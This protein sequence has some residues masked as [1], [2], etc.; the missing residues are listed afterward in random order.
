MKI[1]LLLFLPLIAWASW[2]AWH[3]GTLPAIGESAPDFRLPDQHGKAHTLSDYAGRWLV[4]YFYPKDDTPGC[5]REACT[6]RDGL[7]KLEAAGAAVAGI[8]VDTQDSHR[9]FADKYRLPFDL[10]ADT[11]GRVA[12]QYGVL[13][14]WKIFRMTK[15]T[16]FLISPAGKVQQV[17]QQVDP[18][19]HAD[20]ILA[21]LSKAAQ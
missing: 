6:F 18:E 3:T 17:Y 8:S 12:R 15:R 9:R 21:K 1:A 11:D 13:M 14:D 16:T 10:L 19:R 4:L 7:A 2:R 5:T 20:E